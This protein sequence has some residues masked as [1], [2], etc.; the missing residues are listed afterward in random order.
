MTA[1]NRKAKTLL[2]NE[3]MEASL[4]NDDPDHAADDDDD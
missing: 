1:S 2:V 4:E 3:R